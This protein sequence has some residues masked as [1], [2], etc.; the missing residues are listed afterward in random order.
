MPG[1]HSA[2]A[3]PRSGA[4][5]STRTSAPL[6]VGVLTLVIIYQLGYQA[7]LT[8]RLSQLPLGD[9][10]C[11]ED[12]N[13]PLCV[14]HQ[15][16]KNWVVDATASS[17]D[18]AAVDAELLAYEEGEAPPEVPKPIKQKKKEGAKNVV[19]AVR[20]DAATSV[21]DEAHAHQSAGGKVSFMFG[22]D[23]SL[24]QMPAPSTDPK[25]EPKSAEVKASSKS[26][27][28]NVTTEAQGLLALEE[29]IEARMQ[30]LPKQGAPLDSIHDLKVREHHLLIEHE[31]E[32]MKEHEAELKERLAAMR[33][34]HEDWEKLLHNKISA[35]G[36]DLCSDPARKDYPACRQFLNESE[37]NATVPT[38]GTATTEPSKL[39]G[40][41]VTVAL[42]SAATPSTPKVASGRKAGFMATQAQQKGNLH[43]RGVMQWKQTEL[44]ETPAV[45]L[46][47]PSS[48]N[49][50]KTPV[51][52]M[53][54][55][56]EEASWS[57]MIPKVA[58][59]TVI[60]S[61]ESAMAYARYF[62]ANFVE[63]FRA[64]SYEGPKQL[65]L[66]YHI[67]NTDG[68]ALVKPYAD[69]TFIKAVAAFGNDEFPSTAAYRFGAWAADADVIAR[70][71]FNAW[72]HPQR[73]AMQVR[74]L[75][76]SARPACF[77][78]RWTVLDAGGLNHTQG[79]EESDTKRWDITL[80]GEREWMHKFWYPLLPE[81]RAV[82]EGR[83]A[84]H[85]VHLNAPE[86]SV[87]NAE[88]AISEK[89]E[90]SM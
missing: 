2:S 65:V 39:R 29:Q 3:M 64:Q 74:A 19:A 30:Q 26:N 27:G 66:V 42:T 84:G 1:F 4:D 44:D 21:L 83:E 35:F 70:W 50:A 81:E 16:F 55:E 17:A 25:V 56:L 76:L 5:K 53:H 10:A 9:R 87:Y 62:L 45:V 59:I 40:R 52:V 54:N 12:P 78:Q 79:M 86:L 58:C 46:A 23:G 71:D 31:R 13:S 88:L 22:A 80:V 47:M 6:L 20:W 72:H 7:I 82:L 32:A 15:L 77:L 24:V 43:W 14:E 37:G 60:P 89:V 48:M 67:D 49:F 8:Q 90:D 75:G 18:Q 41:S 69:G 68:A 11:S 33:H 34:E 61:T 57:G 63:N 85:V 28:D 51:L 36:H 73:L 38:S